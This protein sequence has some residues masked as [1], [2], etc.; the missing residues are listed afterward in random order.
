MRWISLILVTDLMLKATYFAGSDLGENVS[1]LDTCPAVMS[2]T[3]GEIWAVQF[4]R[5]SFFFLISWSTKDFIDFWAVTGW[6]K[7]IIAQ[8][9][10][11]G[12]RFE[13]HDLNIIVITNIGI[14]TDLK[15]RSVKIIWWKALV[16]RVV[17]SC[18][19]TVTWM[20]FFQLWGY[21][22]RPGTQTFGQ[23]WFFETVFRHRYKSQPP[24]NPICCPDN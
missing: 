24:L 14:P 21:Q 2:L 6:Q 3:N 17:P 19:E 4:F 16:V 8:K 15:W 18:Q 12:T 7:E 1:E 10:K 23:E 11:S 13:S 5:G 9:G 22:Q 20:V